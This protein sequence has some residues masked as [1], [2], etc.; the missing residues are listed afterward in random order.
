MKKIAG[1]IISPV[2]T[3]NHNHMYGSWDTGWD[4]QDFLSFWAIFYSFTS[5]ATRKIK[6]LKKIKKH[7]EILLVYTNVIYKW[8]WCVVSE[9]WS[10]MDR[11]CCHFGSFFPFYP[12]NNHENQNVQKIL[13]STWRYN[14]TNAYHKWQSYMVHRSWDM[15]FLSF[16]TIFCHFTPLTNQKIKTLKKWKKA[17]RCYY[18]IQIYH[19]W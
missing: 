2:C 10:T 13:K 9:I 14:F 11:I 18:F 19:K 1:D 3:K 15:N 4:R 7:L 6:I 5:L 12:T 17:W 8:Q 16:W